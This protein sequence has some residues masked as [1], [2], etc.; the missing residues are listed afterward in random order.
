MSNREAEALSRALADPDGVVWHGPDR[1]IGDLLEAR[2][3]EIVELTVAGSDGTTTRVDA[4]VRSGDGREWH[5]ALFLAADVQAS[6]V[7]VFQRPAPYVPTAGLVVVLNGASGAGKSTV[8]AAMAD[9]AETPWIVFDEPHVGS[10]QA[11]YLIWRDVA[12]SVHAGAF[13]AIR[14]MAVAGNQVAVAAGGFDFTFVRARLAGVRSVVVG[15]HCSDEVRRERLAEEPFRRPGAAWHR[16]AADVHEGWDYDVE[17]T[18]D[19][20]PPSALAAELLRLA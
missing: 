8:M 2:D 4:K 16:P 12:P 13:D 14:A 6:K 10:V 3:R 11:P 20:R 9:Q 5:V 19:A 1:V 17:L 7:W 18:T 15:L